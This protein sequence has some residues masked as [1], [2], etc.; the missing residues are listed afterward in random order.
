[1]L[2]VCGTLLAVAGLEAIL[3]WV[4]PI[5]AFG[6]GWRTRDTLDQAIE[7][8]LYVAD[9]DLGYRP[10]LGGPVYSATGTLHNDYGQDKRPD[11][12][13]LL[14]IGDS[15]TARCKVVDALRALYGEREFEFWNG[16]VHGFNTIQEVRYY[17]RYNA[18]ISPDHVILTFHN[19]DFRVTPIAFTNSDGT[20]SVVD[21]DR[22][23]GRVSPWLLRLSQL[24][25]RYVR[26]RLAGGV[27]GELASQVPETRSALT[28]LRTTLQRDGVELTILLLPILRSEERWTREETE[29]RRLAR[30][31]FEELGLRYFDLLEPMRTTLEAGED[32]GESPGDSWHP[33]WAAARRF[34]TFLREHGLLIAGSRP[35]AEPVLKADVRSV[36]LRAGGVQSLSLNAGP[37]HAGRSYLVLGSASG[38]SPP[39]SLHLVQLPLASDPY[40][41]LTFSHPNTWITG[42]FGVLDEAGRAR[43]EVRIPAGAP[44]TGAGTVLQHA[45]VVFRPAPLTFYAGSNAVSLELNP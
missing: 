17:E 40:F 16:G 22:D 3:W 4:A 29:S 13:R 39:T 2:V 32:P 30:A 20:F 14:F 38:T 37:T 10:R 26:T 31:L 12:Q 9:E 43:A 35:T 28:R 15:V 23:V 11:V 5:E 19:N 27:R 6:D 18:A 7:Q 45:F 44:P 25:R 41:R 8:D 36:S 34:A 21:P 33:S 1:M 42:S 24:Y